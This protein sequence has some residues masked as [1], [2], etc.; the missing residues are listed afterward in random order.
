MS[1]CVGGR[2]YVG[3]GGGSLGWLLAGGCERARQA[4]LTASQLLQAFLAAHLCAHHVMPLLVGGAQFFGDW[5][6]QCCSVSHLATISTRVWRMWPGRAV[7][8][9]SR[10]IFAFHPEFGE[11]NLAEQSSLHYL[12]LPKSRH[13]DSAE[14]LAER[15]M[16]QWFLSRPRYC[17]SA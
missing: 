5:S 12:V 14:W 17:D 11:R 10:L 3:N 7:S 9:V 16:W 13:G 6:M 8:K 2:V 4:K 15:H 1:P